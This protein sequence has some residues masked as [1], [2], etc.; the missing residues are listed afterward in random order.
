MWSSA[1]LLTIPLSYYKKMGLSGI[2]KNTQTAI[3]NANYMKNKLKDHFKIMEG[4]GDVAHEFIIDVSGLKNVTDLDISKRLIDYSFHPPTMSWPHKSSLMIEPT[5]SEPIE[6]IDRFI[7]ALISIKREIQEKPELLKNAP[8]PLKLLA[9]EWTFPYSQQ[10][11]F[12]PIPSLQ[13]KKHWPSTSR[14]NDLYG[15]KLMYSK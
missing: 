4:E 8:H 12:F 3:K 2:K 10:E 15:D 14:V 13:R 5:E 6:E 7:E 1:S 11:A 9:K